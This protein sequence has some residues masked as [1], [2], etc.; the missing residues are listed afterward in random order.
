MRDLSAS[1]VIVI[2]WLA[3]QVSDIAHL[4]DAART[5]LIKGGEGYPSELD[6]ILMRCHAMLDE[7]QAMVRA[8]GRGRRKHD[9]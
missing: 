4:S 9:A 8:S 6:A 5:T 7:I 3:N 2:R 1:D